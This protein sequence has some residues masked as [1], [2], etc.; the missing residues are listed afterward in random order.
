M[1]K[2]SRT[3][4]LL[5]Q[6]LGIGHIVLPTSTKSPGKTVV[7]MEAELA[8]ML[9]RWS[10]EEDQLA[11]DRLSHFVSRF[12]PRGV[13]DSEVLARLLN[14]PFSFPETSSAFVSYIKRIARSVVAKETTTPP[15]DA[16]YM[17]V[18][19]AA[20]LL[21]DLADSKEIS[22]GFSQAPLY[23]KIKQRKL[24]TTRAAGTWLISADDVR[25]LGK[26]CLAATKL[27]L[28]VSLISKRRGIRKNSAYRNVRRR[29]KRGES[30]DE[31]LSL[32]SR[33]HG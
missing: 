2:T 29:M 9:L 4:K 6:G 10:F 8:L 14:S 7:R 5:F 25:D 23:S 12:V 27:K 1:I 31:I 32:L 13:D 18:P 3:S 33:Q 17:S 15:D 26:S 24:K 28:T 20:A 16:K 11:H 30:L 19:Q 21:R 22:R